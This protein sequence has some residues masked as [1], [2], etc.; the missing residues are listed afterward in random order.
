VA[1]RFRDFWHAKPGQGGVKLDWT[2]TWRNWC[3]EDA[4]RR[5]S[6]PEDPMAK[7]CRVMGLDQPKTID[8]PEQEFL[9]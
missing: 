4:R 7:L 8:H 3:R 6:A 5:P 1:D 2:A 9:I